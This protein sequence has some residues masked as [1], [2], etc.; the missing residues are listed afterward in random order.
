[1]TSID[2]SAATE[3]LD[4]YGCAV[5]PQLLDA[6]ACARVSALWQ[7]EERFRSHIHMA[8]HGFGRGEYRYFAYPLP[9]P[10]AGLREQL[11]PPLAAIANR[12]AERMGRVRRFP[13]SHS[14]F[15]EQ[16]RADGQV[17]PT[18]LILRYGPGDWNALH[19]DVYGEHV[20]PLQVAILLSAPGRDFEGGS[21]C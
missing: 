21:S 1:M 16:C 18:P 3:A 11:Y 4:A 9:E 7:E 12:W 6:N 5:L 10:I 15:L 13:A 8:R 2:W 19:Q 17:R 14:E 20:F